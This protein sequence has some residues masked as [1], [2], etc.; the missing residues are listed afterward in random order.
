[1]KTA[2]DSGS[3]AIMHS[4]C[5]WKEAVN[6]VLVFRLRCLLP[7]GRRTDYGAGVRGV[8]CPLDASAL[9][10]V[11][12]RRQGDPPQSSP[13]PSLPSTRLSCLKHCS[14]STRL[15]CRRSG[16]SPPHLCRRFFECKWGLML[17]SASSGSAVTAGL[18]S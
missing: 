18:V 7:D 3:A 6:L 12:D 8:P 5:L 15:R 9:I 17:V 1:M 13:L 4:D 11:L 10:K 14:Q 16:C 2:A